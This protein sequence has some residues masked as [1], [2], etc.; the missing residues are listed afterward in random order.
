MSDLSSKDKI[1]LMKI[2]L[3][4][5][6]I[7][8]LWKSSESTYAYPKSLLADA[9]N[10]TRSDLRKCLWAVNKARS[11]FM[12]EAALASKYNGYREEIK[13]ADGNAKNLLSEYSRNLAIGK[14]KDAELILDRLIPCLIPPERELYSLELVSSGT[15]RTVLRIKNGSNFMVPVKRITATS[16]GKI[17]SVIPKPPFAVPSNTPKDFEV[18]A[19]P[20]GLS[21]VVEISDPK[22]NRSLTYSVIE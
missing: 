1:T 15:D 10:Y 20:T 16:C 21:V 11:A 2:D 4:V 18:N 6:D 9:R 22:G 13:T 14:Y 3:A 8:R 7:Y 12:E 5:K 17:V 19:S